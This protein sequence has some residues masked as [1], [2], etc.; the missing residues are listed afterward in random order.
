LPKWP[1]RAIFAL[2]A[3]NDGHHTKALE[4]T[5]KWI[6]QHNLFVLVDW[7]FVEAMTLIKSRIGASLAMR[8]GLELR[9]NP[10]YLWKVM[11]PELERETWGIF[12]TNAG[13]QTVAKLK[14]TYF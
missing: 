4:F 8:V 9:E 12:Q 5:R 14:T 3:R 6:V 10:I 2:I 7:V 13:D 1:C 11:T